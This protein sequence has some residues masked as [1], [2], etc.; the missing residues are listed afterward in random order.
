MVMGVLI[1]AIRLNETLL[2]RREGILRF[3]LENNPNRNNL[4]YHIRSLSA[5]DMAIGA[6][7]RTILYSSFEIS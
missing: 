5:I 6:F 3:G 1:F 7:I 4:S 2:H